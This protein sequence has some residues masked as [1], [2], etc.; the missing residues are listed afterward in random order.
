MRYLFNS[1]LLVMLAVM[2]VPVAQADRIKDL[3]SVATIRS[4]QLLGY[5]LVVGLQGT[6]D[7]SDVPF[8]GQSL[9]SMLNKLGVSVDGPLADFDSGSTASAKL[10]VKNIAAVDRKSVV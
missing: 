3:A 4:N 10:D 1:L 8:S 5:G 7:G 6:G 9:R 2:V